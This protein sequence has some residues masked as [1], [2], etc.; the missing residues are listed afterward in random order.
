MLEEGSSS[1]SSSVDPKVQRKYDRLVGMA[2][3][4]EDEEPAI[5]LDLY[6]YV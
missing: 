2:M 3:D 4:I 6:K 5:A 1:P